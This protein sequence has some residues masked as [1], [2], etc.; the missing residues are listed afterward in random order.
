MSVPFWEAM[1]RC[2]ASAYE[3][4]RWFKEQ[5]GPLPGRSG[6]RSRFGQSLTL[7]PD[8][9]AI[10]IGGEHEDYYDTDFCIY[11]DVFLHERDGSV[12]I[13]GYP[14][15]VFPPTDFHTATLAG[16][17]I[18][19]IGCLGYQGTRRPEETRV[20]RLDLHT[21]R[22]ERLDVRGEAPGWIYDHRAALV[23]PHGIRVWGGKVVIECDGRESHQQNLG[24]FVLDLDC[25]LW[26]RESTPGTA[27][28]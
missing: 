13:Y 19:I 20:Y 5:C 12:A 28:W 7:L 11:N 21:M 22:M 9:R 15:S 1:V 14:E 17:S 24:C 2:G 27:S 8:G 10:Q 18:Y 6:A 3:A 23:N 16:D 26:H 25:L 4:R